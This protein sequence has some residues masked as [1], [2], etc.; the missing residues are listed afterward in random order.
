VGKGKVAFSIS[1]ALPHQFFILPVKVN[2][3]L[4]VLPLPEAFMHNEE[5][6]YR[7]EGEGIEDE[8][9]NEDFAIA[10]DHLEGFS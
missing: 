2:L 5:D 4:R 1:P 9:S 3:H 7:K 8:G 6:E 10:P